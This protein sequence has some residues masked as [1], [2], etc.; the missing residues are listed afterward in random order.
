[1]IWTGALRQAFAAARL[2]K[3]PP[4]A[5]R[6]RFGRQFRQSNSIS[7]CH[8][9]VSLSHPFLKLLSAKISANLGFSRG[10]LD[11]KDVE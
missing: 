2:S 11:V 7:I 8:C 6:A 9:S 10:P 3:P 1:M 4:R 5:V